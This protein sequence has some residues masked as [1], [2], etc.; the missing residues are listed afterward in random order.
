MPAANLN[1]VWDQ[2]RSFP[3]Q[4]LNNRGD[5]HYNC[6]WFIREKREVEAFGAQG[7]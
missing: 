4:K 7:D 3:L 5:L 6:F 1:A 2:K